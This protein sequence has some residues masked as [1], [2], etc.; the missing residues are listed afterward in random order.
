MTSV[1]AKNSGTPVVTTAIGY[2]NTDSGTSSQVETWA[3][4]IGAATSAAATY[5]YTYDARGNITSILDGDTLLAEYWYDSLD[6]LTEEKDY[7]FD[8][9]WQYTYD[10]GGNIT[11]RTEYAS[12]TATTGGVTTTYTY[13]DATWKDLLTGY[14]GKTLTY[15][16]VGNLISD[17]TW[18]YTWD[19]GRRLVA[20]S[21]ANTSATYTYNADGLRTSKTLNGTTYHYSYLG[22]KLVEMTWD[23]N[24][25]SFIHDAIGPA[26][27]IFNGTTY[28][29]TRNAQ[30]DIT[31]IVGLNEENE[32]EQV[33]SY[34]YNAWGKVWLSGE[35]VF[36]LGI[37]N[38]FTYRGY[39]MDLFEG[40][41][42]LQS[43]YYNPGWGRFINAD[44]YASTGQG[45]VGNNMFAYCGNN[46][47]NCKDTEG[48][49]AGL[50]IGGIIGAV[51]G[52]LSAKASGQ[53]VLFGAVIGGLA[54]VASGTVG[55]FVATISKLGT[56]IAVSAIANGLIGAGSNAFNQYVNYRLQDKAK[57]ENKENGIVTTSGSTAN[58]Q[59]QD[60]A[61][62]AYNKTWEEYFDKSAV[63]SAFRWGVVGGAIGGKL[64]HGGKQTIN[65]G[66]PTY[67]ETQGIAIDTASSV[68]LNMI[69]VLI[70][71]IIEPTP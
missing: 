50:I 19:H 34:S 67:D 56:A 12:A 71:P 46:P 2:K 22:D 17:G 64:S 6:Q 16:E 62:A 44:G 30:G 25:M 63:R 68:G 36:T 29:Y 31:G 38:P 14:D 21:S 49:I 70:D 53:N 15:D 4:T 5:T 43:R 65:L 37:Y 69:Q 52:A 13:G 48:T 40:L 9:R 27:L 45:I 33:V 10:N 24:K 41:Y 23:N 18:T 42:Y 51:T 55:L 3:N 8:K 28:Y 35:Q 26:A 1:T 58:G 32:Y 61:D 39:V 66:W 60:V 57:R 47:V 11:S 20:A 54:G 59:R 7:S